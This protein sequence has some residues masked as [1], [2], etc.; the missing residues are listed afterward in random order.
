M[1]S[2]AFLLGAGVSIAASMPG[3]KDITNEILYCYDKWC[4]VFST[5]R[6]ETVEAYMGHSSNKPDQISVLEIGKFINIVYTQLKI[7]AKDKSLVSY[8][9]IYDAFNQIHSTLSENYYNPL[10]TPFLNSLK[11][12]CDDEIDSPSVET[13]IFIETVVRFRLESNGRIA[14]LSPLLKIINGSSNKDIHIFTLNFD[15]LIEEL[16]KEKNISYDDGFTKPL[17]NEQ[18]KLWQMDSLLDYSKRKI[19]LYKLHGSFDW[20]HLF[21]GQYH[22]QF[23]KKINTMKYYP[24]FEF[25]GKDRVYGRDTELMGIQNKLLSYNYGIFLDMLTLFHLQL[26]RCNTLIISGYSF[27]DYGVNLR[28]MDW[29]TR[30]QDSKIIF[31]DP[32]SE[33]TLKK[34][35]GAIFSQFNDWISKNRMLVFNDCFNK[36]D[37]EYHFPIG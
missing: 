8:E 18:V 9:D 29:M 34:A 37:G 25:E 36:W 35:R 2:I 23:V 5:K 31:I 19:G 16:L 10:I 32:N 7:I 3:T 22:Y 4:E 28:I 27:S 24:Y 6:F 1:K 21:G 30:Y 12:I 17:Y 14:Q 13:M 15:T 20:E 11:E 33:D 26:K